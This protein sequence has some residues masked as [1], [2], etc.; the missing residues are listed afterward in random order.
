MLNITALA[1]IFYV[2][3]S[4]KF[5]FFFKQKTAY[6]MRISDWSSDVCSSDLRLRGAAGARHDGRSQ[7]RYP[8]LTPERRRSFGRTGAVQADP[9]PARPLSC[10]RAAGAPAWRDRRINPKE[11]ARCSACVRSA[12]SPKRWSPPSRKI[13]REHVG[14][15]VTNAHLV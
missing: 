9:A 8:R 3:L 14:T 10:A 2:L 4:V 12:S 1:F 6:E 7:H 11:T 15:P 5:F 13:G